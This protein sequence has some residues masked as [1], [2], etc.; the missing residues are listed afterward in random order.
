MGEKPIDQRRRYLAYLLRL[1]QEGSTDQ[2]VWRASLESPQS[3]ERQGFS[4]LADLFDFLENRT[5]SGLPHSQDTEEEG[6]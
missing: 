2:P 1:W 5:Q 4:G 6:R 3:G